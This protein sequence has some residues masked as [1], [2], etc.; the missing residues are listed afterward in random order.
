MT[1]LTRI[2]IIFCVWA[3]LPSTSPCSIGRHAVPQRL[4]TPI[5]A[6]YSFCRTFLNS[7]P[8]SDRTIVGAVPDRKMHCANIL[9]VSTA[10]HTLDAAKSTPWQTVQIYVITYRL[11]SLSGG[12]D[13]PSKSMTTSCQHSA[14]IGI[15][16]GDE[17]FLAT[18][19]KLIHVLHLSTHCSTSCFIPFH[20]Q[21][22]ESKIR[23]FSALL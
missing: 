7:G 23:V 17:V 2:P 11:P 21:M 19:R 1:S 18:L 13:G 4:D 20:Q 9:R 10:L 3:C 5:S 6:A 12:F 15:A 14:V 16:G 22:R 8:L